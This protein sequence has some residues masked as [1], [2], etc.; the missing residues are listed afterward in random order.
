MKVRDCLFYSIMAIVFTAPVVFWVWLYI[1]RKNQINFYNR[2][3]PQYQFKVGSNVWVMYLLFGLLYFSSAIILFVVDRPDKS[4]KLWV[5][6]LVLLILGCL[7]LYW[8]CFDM[9]HKLYFDYDTVTYKEFLKK[10]ICFSNKQIVSYKC[11]KAP[12][13]GVSALFQDGIYGHFPQS[14]QLLL[15]LS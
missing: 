11:F 9:F 2:H 3:E 14:V 12:W 13:G 15:M 7:Y 1:T 8:A 5:C 6:V 10:P 4:T